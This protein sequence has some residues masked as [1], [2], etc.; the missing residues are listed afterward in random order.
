M[1]SFSAE[2]PN[3]IEDSHRFG[4]FR[5]DNAKRV[6]WR[7]GELVYLPPRSADLLAVLLEHRGEVLE[8]NELIDRVWQDTFVEEGNLNYTI[9]ILRKALGL[10]ENGENFIQTIP[11]KGY[12]FLD[13]PRPEAEVIYEKRSLT[14]TVIE[15]IHSSDPEST[16]A[17]ATQSPNAALARGGV[18]ALS[19]LAVVIAGAAFAMTWRSSGT[20]ATSTPSRGV[21]SIAVLPFRSPDHD[22]EHRGLGLADIV[23]TRLS[24]LSGI[25]IRP[26]SSVMAFENQEVDAIKVGQE[27]QADAVL[28]GMIHRT[29]DT[30]H[31]TARLVR[32]ADG[33]SLWSGVFE[34]PLSDELSVESEIVAQLAN[35]LALNSSSS[36]ASER[37]GPYTTNLDAY[38]LYVRGRYE[39]NKRDLQGLHEAQR[40]FRNAIAAD[41]NF[42]LAHVGLADSLVFDAETQELYDAIAKALELD[43]QLGE[44]YATY[45]FTLALHQ[46]KWNEAEE[47]FKKAIELSPSYATAHQWYAVLLGIEGRTQEAEAEMKRAVEINP[48]SH[49]FIADL[50]EIYY[51][52]RDYEKAEEYCR[53][54]LAI[55]PDFPFA[56]GHLENIYW[57]TG[58]YELAINEMVTK[59]EV[60]ARTG[61]ERKK[62]DKLRD[63]YLAANE[64]GGL[65]EFVRVHERIY[66]ELPNSGR[67]P[68]S[69]YGF[70]AWYSLMGEKEKALDNLE[71]ALERRAFL[72]AWVKADPRFDELR[73]EPRYQEILRKMGLS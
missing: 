59:G 32:V 46:W 33:A 41:P 71:S 18:V 21:K 44:A 11:R 40:L 57:R 20:S 38:Q 1:R 3:T 60:N 70:A 48:L 31:V 56:H 13:D 22:A 35:A 25:T 10:N 36:T 52:Q 26:T 4:N 34:K 67:N 55:Y 68:N 43:P 62:S 37:G 8:R 28:D 9:S 27:L 15:E 29:S 65:A 66:R 42:A 5:F 53:R 73:S 39:W 51:F 2:N 23:I 69:P 45:A 14:E 24:G 61:S 63:I 49:N 54:A 19:V 17:L 50:G 47:N 72:M 58:R 7:N 30:V 16:T 64:R 6:L 12:R